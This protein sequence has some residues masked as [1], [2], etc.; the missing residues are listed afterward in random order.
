MIWN[1]TSGL[2]ANKRRIFKRS[3]TLPRTDGKPIKILTVI[4]TAHYWDLKSSPSH[5]RADPAQIFSVRAVSSISG[6]LEIGWS[7]SETDICLRMFANADPHAKRRLL[8]GSWLD[9]SRIPHFSF[10][11]LLVLGVWHVLFII[12]WQ[13]PSLMS[14][15]LLNTLV[16]VGRRDLC[17]RGKGVPEQCL[18]HCLIWGSSE[19]FWAIAVRGVRIQRRFSSDQ[20][21]GSHP[22]RIQNVHSVRFRSTIWELEITKQFSSSICWCRNW[23][24]DFSS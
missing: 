21:I 23:V 13:L 10:C 4:L 8:P 17:L 16:E 12:A 2:T 24:Y 22:Y 9:P 20:A 5:C 6:W 15:L 3:S 19:D 7:W 14:W 18:F 11:F 1:I